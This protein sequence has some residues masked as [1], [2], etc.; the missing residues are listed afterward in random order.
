MPESGDT[1]LCPLPL[2]GSDLPAFSGLQGTGSR[3]D[4]GKGPEGHV[5]HATPQSISELPGTVPRRHWAPPEPLPP[6]QA[7]P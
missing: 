7:H 2:P 1:R 6:T 3:P 4:A 5:C